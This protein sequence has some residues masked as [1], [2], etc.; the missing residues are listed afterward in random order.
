VLL[1]RK[2][3]EA[4]LDRLIQEWTVSRSA[5]EVMTLMQAAGVAAGVVETGEDLLEKD[6]QLKYRMTFV[7]LE[8]PEVGKYRTQAGTHFLASKMTFEM[9]R[10]PLLGEHNRYVFQEILGL[11]A[12]EMDRLVK[13]EV[14][15]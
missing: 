11:S 8:H 5:E 4:E 12:E 2:K 13:E 10:A 3:N 1:A 14:I 6:P 9:R 15:H 7:E